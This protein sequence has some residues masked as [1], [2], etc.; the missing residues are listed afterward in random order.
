MPPRRAVLLAAITAVTLPPASAVA[1]PTD[2]RVAQE[3]LAFR[4]SWTPDPA[5]S[6]YVVEVS[7]S[8][9][10]PNEVG[11]GCTDAGLAPRTTALVRCLLAFPDGAYVR[12]APYGPGTAAVVRVPPTGFSFAPVAV[13]A[14]GPAVIRNRQVLG[15]AA[16]AADWTGIDAATTFTGRVTSGGV[17]RAK[18]DLRSPLTGEGPV[19]STAAIRY[20]VTGADVGRALRCEV[21]ASNGPLTTT[22]VDA[23]TVA[24]ALPDEMRPVAVLAELDVP[25]AFAFEGSARSVR[26]RPAEARAGVL[27]RAVRQAKGLS[28][29]TTREVDARLS[30]YSRPARADAQIAPRAFCRDLRR[31]YR[32]PSRGVLGCGAA[33]VPAARRAIR[34]TTFGTA[35]RDD[36]EPL[37]VIQSIVVASAGNCVL[38]LDVRVGGPFRAR[39]SDLREAT[40]TA[41]VAGARLALGAARE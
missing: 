8:P 36:G 35:V 29:F 12:V 37:V 17:E 32:G 11:A 31:A 22:R 19:F 15:C 40:R 25:K 16:L 33:H 13:A 28:V 18:A 21:T 23:A 26:V 27:S 38:T 9:D 6:E 1:A 39:A 30:V 24:H 4:V 3:G 34:A 14:A 2:I 41:D 7:R 5:A 10:F 20:A